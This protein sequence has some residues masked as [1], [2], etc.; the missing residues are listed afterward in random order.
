M[1]NYAMLKGSI[2][3]VFGWRIQVASNPNDR[4]LRTFPMQANGAEML[5]LACCLATER[6]IEVCAPVHDAVLIVAP[7]GRLEADIIGMQS[8]MC[9][10]SRIVL[11]GF[12]LGTDTAEFRHP[13]RYMDERGK[14]MWSKVMTLVDRTEAGTVVQQTAGCCPAD[15]P[16]VGIHDRVS[17]AT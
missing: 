16:G 1:L 3:T 6:G 12:E 17:E 11:G 15:N 2:H 9:E 7:L 8:A 10:A 13:E 14:T 4:S 5:R